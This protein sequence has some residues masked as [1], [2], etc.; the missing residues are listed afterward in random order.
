MSGRP[1]LRT[2]RRKPPM[3]VPGDYYNKKSQIPDRRL[4]GSKRIAALI[5]SRRCGQS[6]GHPGKEDPPR[7]W[8]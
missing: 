3:N 4:C 2:E 6:E 8:A 5:A 7:K 1:D